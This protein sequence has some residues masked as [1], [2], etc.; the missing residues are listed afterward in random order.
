MPP[1]VFCKVFLLPAVAVLL[2][3]LGCLPIFI[4]IVCF[5]LLMVVGVEEL[6]CV[7]CDFGGVQV[8]LF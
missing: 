5:G 8:L 3:G 6:C 2:R 7:V 4:V 1:Y